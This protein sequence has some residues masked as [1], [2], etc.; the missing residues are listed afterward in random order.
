MMSVVEAIHE[1]QEG[2]FRFTRKYCKIFNVAGRRSF[3]KYMQTPFK[4][5]NCDDRKEIIC[6]ADEQNIQLF[7]KVLFV[8]RIKADPIRKNP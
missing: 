4:A 3:T 6:E 7:G 8:I 1:P 5:V 2:V